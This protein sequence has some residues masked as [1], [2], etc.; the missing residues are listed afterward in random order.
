VTIE[1]VSLGCELVFDIEVEEY[2]AEYIS[3]I[4]IT[5]PTCATPGEIQFTINTQGDVN[6]LTMSVTHPNGADVFMVEPGVLLL[7]EYMD[8]TAGDYTVEIFIGDA[9]PDCIESFSATIDMVQGITIV[10][11]AVFPP[12]S[13]SGMDGSAIII[14]SPP[15]D[16]P[17]MIFVNGE[18][19]GSSPGEII[20]IGGLG[21]GAYTVQVIDASG[22]E[23]NE[24]IIMVPFPDNI[25]A[26]GTGMV[27]VSASTSNPEHTTVDEGWANSTWMSVDYRVGKMPQRIRITYIAPSFINRHNS[28]SR[29]RGD[30][31]FPIEWKPGDRLAMV[32]SAGIGMDNFQHLWNAH[33]MLEGE[34]RW[35]VGKK[36]SVHGLVNTLFGEQAPRATWSVNIELPF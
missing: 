31:A 7:S 3:D 19:Y 11:E 9:G 36:M 32:A 10:E 13:P 18:L 33:A 34:V 1:D 16:A 27:N 21:V 4:I 28:T 35:Q 30:Y 14:V 15:G 26:F 17:Y 2:P 29:L 8:I 20:E 23:S 12:S 25:L 5:Q 24:L 6:F 22:C